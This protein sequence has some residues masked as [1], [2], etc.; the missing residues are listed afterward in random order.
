MDEPRQCVV[1]E[2]IV[3]LIHFP[4]HACLLQ[5]L[6]VRRPGEARFAIISHR[7]ATDAIRIDHP[8][9]GVEPVGICRSQHRAEIRVADRVRLRQGIIKT[10]L[11]ARVIG[12][13]RGAFGEDPLIPFAKVPGSMSGEPIMRHIVQTLV[14][15]VEGQHVSA[16]SRLEQGRVP[17]LKAQNGAIAIPTHSLQRAKILVK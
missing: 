10:Q 11:G 9:H 16:D 5:S 6:R 13:R 3:F 14:R 15:D 7:A 8:S 1:V 2:V 17:I 12:Q 4:T